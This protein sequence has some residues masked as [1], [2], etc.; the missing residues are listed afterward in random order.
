MSRAI[1]TR[2][3]R[4]KAA[5]FSKVLPGR[6]PPLI[7]CFAYDWLFRS[8]RASHIIPCMDSNPAPIAS[9]GESSCAF[10]NV[11]SGL[12]ATRANPSL[13]DMSH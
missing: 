3:A 5:A 2:R 1:L 4:C 13:L 7:D 11:F 6:Q 8:L 12:H 10:S 9:T